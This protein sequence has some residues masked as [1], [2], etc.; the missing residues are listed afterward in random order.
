MSLWTAQQSEWLEAMGLQVLQM[1]AT[2][3]DEPLPVARAASE[4]RDHVASPAARGSRL[5]QALLHALRTCA[6]PAAQLASLNIDV[7]ALRN[8]AAGKR[9]LWPRLRALRAGRT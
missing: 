4:R 6:D 8:D 9:A 7:D 1:A 2:A 5:Q 3:P